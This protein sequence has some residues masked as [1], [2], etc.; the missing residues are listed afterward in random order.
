VAHPRTTPRVI[1]FA[2]YSTAF[3]RTGAACTPVTPRPRLRQCT[4]S[5]AH[6]RRPKGTRLTPPVPS[7]PFRAAM[8]AAKEGGGT[9]LDRL[10]K[11]LE[12]ARRFAYAVVACFV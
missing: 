8:A 5:L 3:T 9:R 7:P 6:A 4:R 11:L 2:R 10:L 12:S 1:L